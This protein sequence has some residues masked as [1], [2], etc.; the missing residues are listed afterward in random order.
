MT[1]EKKASSPLPKLL[2]RNIKERRNQLGW[3]QATLAELVKVDVETISRIERGAI[4]PSILKLEQLASVLGLP[5]AELLRSSSTLAD[6]QTLEILDWMK[7]LSET[8]RRFVLETVRGLCR[9]L[10]NQS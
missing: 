2:G 9:H 3:T 10:A 1:K 4:L 5:L 7:N 8:D 6:D